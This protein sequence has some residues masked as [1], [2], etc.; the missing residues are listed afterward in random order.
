MSRQI[1]RDPFARTTLFKETIRPGPMGIGGCSECGN[2]ARSRIGER[3][4]FTFY[5]ETDGGRKFEHPGCFC[6]VA[7]CRIYNQFG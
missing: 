5:T 7:C 3:R 1:S 4:L 2:Y 6:S